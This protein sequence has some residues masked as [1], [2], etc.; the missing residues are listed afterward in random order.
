MTNSESHKSSRH[1]ELPATTATHEIDAALRS[2]RARARSLLIARRMGAVFAAVFGGAVVVAVLDYTLR[3]PLAFR[4]AVWIAGAVALV[5]GFRTLILPALRFRPSLTEIALRLERSDGGRSARG[6]LASALELAQQT[7]SAE[8][9]DFMRQRVVA[10]ATT[11]FKQIKASALLT[12]RPAFRDLGA[13][14]GVA[15]VVAVLL[16]ISPTLTGIG[17][18][19]TLAP[20]LGTSWPK[21]TQVVDVTNVTVHPSGSALALRAAI[22]KTDRPPRE[23]QVGARYR[24]IVDGEERPVRRATLTGQG[25]EV[26]VGDRGD[27]TGE[28]YE[29]LIEPGIL[30]GA[31]ASTVQV[32]YWF[33]TPDD[34]TTEKRVLLVEPPRVQSARATVAPP[35]YASAAIAGGAPIVSGRLDL[36]AG[37]DARAVVGPVLAGSSIELSIELNK[38]VPA[39]PADADQEE[40]AR[41]AWSTF[42]DEAVAPLV[43][44]WGDQGVITLE[45]TIDQATRLPV[46]LEDEHGLVGAEESVFAFEVVRDAVA[47]AVVTDPPEDEAVLP[48]AVVGLSGEGRD[49]AGLLWLALE[50]QIARRPSESMGA[51]AEATTEITEIKRQTYEASA[52]PL[53]ANASAVL[54]LEDFDLRAGDEIRITARAQDTFAYQG[55]QHEPQRSSIRTLRIISEEDFVEQLRRELSGIRASG[56][57]LDEEQR[58]VQ[59]RVAQDGATERNRAQQEGVTQR[60]EAQQEVVERLAE[61]VGRNNLRDRA[62]TEMLRDAE[63]LL[64]DAA[65]SSAEASDAMTTGRAPSSELTEQEQQQTDQAQSEVRDNLEQLIEMLD[66][67]EDSWLS[68]RNIER[69]LDEQR[70]LIERTAEASRQTLGRSEQELTTAER[71]LLDAI[72]EAQEGLADRTREAMQDLD[73]R[74]EQMQEVDPAQADAMSQAAQRGRESQV[75]QNQREAAQ[76][77]EQNRTQQAQEQQEEAMEALE[78]V[79]ED[80]DEAERNRDVALQ[81]V[82]ASAID[83]I[84]GLIAHQETELEK[85]QPARDSG[86]ASGLELGMRRLRI[87]TLGVA[88]ELRTTFRELE[89]VAEVLDEA[90]EAQV[91]AIV[92]IGEPNLDRTEEME[93]ESLDA[94]ERARALAEEIQDEAE[95]RERERKL[96]ELEQRYRD[97]LEQQVAIRAET[98]TYI[99]VRLDRRQRAE[100]RGLAGRQQSISDQS[101]AMLTEFEELRQI[102][103]FE[104]AHERLREATSQAAERLALADEVTPAVIRRQDTAIRLL[105]SLLQALEDEQQ[106]PEDEFRG[107]EQGGGG[108]GGAGGGQSG[109][110]PL[111]PPLQEL[112]LLR[113]IQ[114]EAADI[115]RAIEDAPSPDAEEVATVG[116]LQRDLAR[117]A[118]G[119]IERL[120][121]QGGGPQP[122]VETGP[123]QTDPDAPGPGDNQGGNP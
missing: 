14:A 53:Q 120:G 94:L 40:L 118:E 111:I 60:I 38:P 68:R 29:S 16:G 12:Q 70:E 55:Q 97:L 83:S 114:Q 10:Q 106:R 50:R 58:E 85:I 7:P 57:R 69:L 25:R 44:A 63:T 75:E 17:A 27:Q 64:R 117:Q 66:R 5:H 105:Q 112:V 56:I 36:G 26:V 48:S 82:L 52:A 88:D 116:K 73:D 1:G 100:V 43:T 67:G 79:L 99:D 6:L 77:I 30:A 96:Q 90:G 61:R 23:T 21:R 84:R 41:R 101:E 9:T 37:S 92:A 95:S 102:K 39:P 91:E 2:L 47:T 80:L 3:L 62:L 121:Q 15:A 123:G 34:R 42:G 46:M 81:R 110:Q 86:D 89:A 4:M 28:L 87:N 11:A 20:W 19:R 24:L 76:N 108:G 104:F 65:R 18:A 71:S 31:A 33:E 115:T 122:E 103:V 49:D 109:D 98:R 72:A 54:S 45:W 22:T 59:D 51:P 13:L 78:N 113:A 93:L 119:L 8:T 74:S 35:P 32:E 107:G